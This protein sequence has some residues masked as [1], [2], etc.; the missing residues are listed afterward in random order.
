MM[1]RVSGSGSVYVYKLINDTW[2]ETQKIAGASDTVAGDHFGVGVA[3]DGDTLAIGAQL[4]DDKGVDSGSVYVYKLIN[5]TWTETHKIAGASDTVAGDRF[6]AGPALDGDTLA[7]GAHFDDDK[8]VDSGNVYMYKLSPTIGRIMDR[9]GN[10]HQITVTG[11]TV[12]DD[13]A[14][15]FGE[16]TMNFD[17]DGDYLSVGDTS[18]FKFLHDGTTDYTVECWLQ[19]SNLLNNTPNPSRIMSTARSSTDSGVDFFVTANGLLGY[20]I[21]GGQN[22]QAYKTITLGSN[23]ALQPNTWYH[24]VVKNTVTHELKIYINGVEQAGTTIIDPSK[25]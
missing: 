20:W 8:G 17:G 18:T 9:S 23:S 4:D 22:Q 14:T 3:L 16:D 25:S 12:V 19:V 5:D 6:G 10:G 21:Y 11:D 13:T 2:T 1:T 24:I 7:I 15:L